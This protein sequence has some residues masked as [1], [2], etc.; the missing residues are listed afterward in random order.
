MRGMQVL[1]A[2]R[3]LLG[4]TTKSACRAVNVVRDCPDLTGTVTDY[5][6]KRGQ[7]MDLADKYLCSM[8]AGKAPKRKEVRLL[9]CSWSNCCTP[10]SRRRGVAC[11][12]PVVVCAGP[13]LGCFC[14][15]V[16][17]LAQAL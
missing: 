8:R 4:L 5:D 2:S 11:C 7:L 15:V 9:L 10:T 16:C 6:K 14:C 3:A 12:V 17:W 1:A 13:L